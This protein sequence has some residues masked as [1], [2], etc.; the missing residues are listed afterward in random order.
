ML[1][2]SGPV[3][4]CACNLAVSLDVYFLQSRRAGEAVD[5]WPEDALLSAMPVRTGADVAEELAGR[6]LLRY[7]T[8]QHAPPTND[9]VWTT[10]TA[11]CPACSGPVLHLPAQLALRHWVF[12]IDPA[13]VDAIQGPRR[14]IMGTGIE[15][16]LPSGYEARALVP[17]G[18][19]VRVR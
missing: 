8:D 10:T 3:A 5:I 17:P 11:I 7:V 6:P 13:Q 4:S 16:I 12:V 9:M 18:Y 1:P 15:Y 2:A 19:G 14:C